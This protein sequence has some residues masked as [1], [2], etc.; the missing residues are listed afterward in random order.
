VTGL[1]QRIGNFF[2]HIGLIV[3]CKDRVG[4]EGATGV[5]RPFGGDALTFPDRSGNPLW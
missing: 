3:P 1:L 5:D 4:I 2:R